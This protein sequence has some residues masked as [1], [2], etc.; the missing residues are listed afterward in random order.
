MKWN[1]ICF[2]IGSLV[3]IAGAMHGDG[4]WAVGIGI[5]IGMIAILSKDVVAIRGGHYLLGLSL[6]PTTM[7]VVG[8]LRESGIDAVA[9]VATNC[10]VAV[11]LFGV[12]AIRAK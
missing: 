12:A 4:H 2:I 1:T 11:L 3:G 7:G 9:I 5:A 6:A 10:V 8:V